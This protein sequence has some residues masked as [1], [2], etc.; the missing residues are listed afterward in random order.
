M[1]DPLTNL[2]SQL[3][4][5]EARLKLAITLGRWGDAVREAQACA[6]LDSQ[7]K[8]AHADARRAPVNIVGRVKVDG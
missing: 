7:I 6:D 3:V 4:Q 1:P 2:R 5:A 8:V